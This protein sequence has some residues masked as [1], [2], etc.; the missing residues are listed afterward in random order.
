MRPSFLCSVSTFILGMLAT[1]CQTGVS[2]PVGGRALAFTN[3]T[4]VVTQ[5]TDPNA[6]STHVV[7][8]L[9]LTNRATSCEDLANSVL[10]ENQELLFVQLEDLGQSGTDTLPT[11][12]A[13]A[14][15]A[16]AAENLSGYADVLLL[17]NDCQYTST[18]HLTATSGSVTLSRYVL[19]EQIDAHFDLNFSAGHLV[20]TLPALWC[21]NVSTLFTEST[22]DSQAATASCLP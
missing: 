12:G 14:I 13:Y 10:R 1:G 3:A 5:V 20:G 6:Q 17:D 4:F 22:S 2:G 9:Y 8:E 7:T 11:L 16:G 19:A 21:T 18:S 15:D